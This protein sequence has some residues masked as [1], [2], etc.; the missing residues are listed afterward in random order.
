MKRLIAGAGMALLLASCGSPSGEVDYNLLPVKSG[1]R[2]GYVN[3]EGKYVINPQF[4]DATMFREGIAR[5]KKDGKYGYIGQDG[6]YICLPIYHDATVFQEGI[7]WVTKEKGAPTAIDTQG[8]ELFTVKE[9]YNVSCYSEGLADFSLRTG[10]KGLILHGYLD[11][12]GNVV[13]PPTYTQAGDFGQG[14]AA[15]SV[16]WSPFGYIDKKGETKINFQFGRAERFDEHGRAIV[17]AEGPEGLCGVINRKGEYVINPLFAS[18]TA[19]GDR[20]L[21]QLERNGDYGYCDADGTLTINPQFEEALPFC[22]SQLAAVNIGD[23]YGY[24]NEKGEIAITP[25]FQGAAPFFGGRAPVYSSSKIGFIDEE[26]KFT[27][28]PQFQEL[29][30]DYFL[31]EENIV[32]TP[33]THVTSQYIDTDRLAEQLR[34]LLADGKLDGMSFPPSVSEVLKRYKIEEKSVPVYDDWKQSLGYWGNCLTAKLALNGYFYKEVSDGWWGTKRLLDKEAKADRVQ[35]HI[36]LFD[37]ATGRSADVRD[38]LQKALNG[39]EYG[40]F[41]FDIRC[42]GGSEV[43]IDITK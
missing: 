10:D 43:I 17:K 32:G 22:G 9:A 34:A 7:A 40:A 41:H 18:L 19:D 42:E 4:D 12:K 14:L 2:Y 21:L 23:L 26:G 11:K 35:L 13:I 8:K 5:V 38:G 15:V 25:Q 1:G 39:S 28:N 37:V 36:S 27:V 31:N 16:D 20:Y 3:P 24:I 33:F 6:N 29:S 30:G